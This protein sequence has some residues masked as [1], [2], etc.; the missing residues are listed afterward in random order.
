MNWYFAIEGHSHGPVSEQKLG[1]LA[2]TGEVGT[3][4]LI[5]HPGRVEWEPVWKLK[6]EIVEQLNMK[7]M[8]QQAKGTTDRIPVAETAIVPAPAGASVGIFRR[9]FGRLRGK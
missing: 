2:R 5:W 9:L 4:T 7:A 3:D 1:E 6:P 8:A